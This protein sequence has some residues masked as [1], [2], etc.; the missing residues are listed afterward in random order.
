VIPAWKA[1]LMKIVEIPCRGTF[2]RRS[3]PNALLV[4]AETRADDERYRQALSLFQLVIGL[5][6]VIG[7]GSIPQCVRS[8]LWSRERSGWVRGFP[9][10][11]RGSVLAILDA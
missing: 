6:A 2:T 3:S 5:S 1:G 10:W 11:W 7:V 9:R 8:R 4:T